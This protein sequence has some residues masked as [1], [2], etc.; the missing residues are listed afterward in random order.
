[1]VAYHCDDET[2]RSGILLKYNHSYLVLASAHRMFYELL[3]TP[4]LEGFG[5]FSK[6]A[7]K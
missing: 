1:M 5:L 7:L 6:L 2:N 4:T 3:N